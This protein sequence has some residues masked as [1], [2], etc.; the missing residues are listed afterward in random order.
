MKK[1]KTMKKM[2]SMLLTVMMVAMLVVT[3]IT[4]AYATGM[5]IPLNEDFVGETVDSLK[6]QGWG[7]VTANKDISHVSIANNQLVLAPSNANINTGIYFNLDSA[8]KDAP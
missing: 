1:M 5:S 2:V 6:A 7:I 3:P 4:P 8:I